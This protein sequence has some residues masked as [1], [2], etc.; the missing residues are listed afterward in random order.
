MYNIVNVPLLSCLL[1]YQS[2][3]K[4]EPGSLTDHCMHY[5]NISVLNSQT[6]T[7]FGIFSYKEYL[8]LGYGVSETQ[9]VRRS[10]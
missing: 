10:N 6:K 8:K 1:H 3:C 9:N 5:T 4:K 7:H 2:P